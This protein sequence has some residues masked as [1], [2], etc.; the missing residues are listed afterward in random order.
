MRRAS[1]SVDDDVHARVSF[2]LIPLELNPMEGICIIDENIHNKVA[3]SDER[4]RG[5]FNDY[6]VEILGESGRVIQVVS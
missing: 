2:L 5:E 3:P 1:K 6:G 4:T